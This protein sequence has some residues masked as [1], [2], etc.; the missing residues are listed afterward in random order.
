[1][2]LSSVNSLS[3]TYIAIDSIILNFNVDFVDSISKKYINVVSLNT[4]YTTSNSISL[5]NNF[6][7]NFTSGH[8]IQVLP[9]LVGLK[10]IGNTFK[11]TNSSTD[12]AFYTEPL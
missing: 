11:V 5:V 2:N 8:N 12:Y 9:F 10:I 6:A 3:I 4:N 7:I 1:M